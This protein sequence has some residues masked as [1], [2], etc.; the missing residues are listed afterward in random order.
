MAWSFRFATLNKNKMTQIVVT[1]QHPHLDIDAWLDMLDL[2]QYNGKLKTNKIFTHVGDG[3]IRS[4]DC[5]F[6]FQKALQ[7]SLVSKNSFIFVKRTSNSW[8]FETRLIVHEWCRAW[9]RCV[10]NTN[11]VCICVVSFYHFFFFYIH[12]FVI[13]YN[14]AIVH[15][16]KMQIIV[17][18]VLWISIIIAMTLSRWNCEK[19]PMHCQVWN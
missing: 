7:S 6:E 3:L 16:S 13:R 15:Q 17:I 5:N 18:V 8:G 9:L 12:F 1:P 10:T 14:S 4:F 11:V 19:M 2:R